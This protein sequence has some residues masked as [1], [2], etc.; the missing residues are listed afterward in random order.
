MSSVPA[1][2]G[3]QP[4]GPSNRGRYRKRSHDSQEYRT[5]P[6]EAS[7]WT[8]G[9]AKGE[10]TSLYIYMQRTNTTVERMIQLI[11][12]SDSEFAELTK[13]ADAR[14]AIA[15]KIDAM[16]AFRQRVLWHFK[17]MLGL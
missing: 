16:M 8:A 1:S 14:P 9:G 10:A 7:Q 12:V 3:S 11:C 13:W 17:A 6:S 2:L 4:R 5:G 15:H